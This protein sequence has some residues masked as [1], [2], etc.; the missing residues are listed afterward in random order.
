[1]LLLVR[2]DKIM[3]I[4]TKDAALAGTGIVLGIGILAGDLHKLVIGA[5]W[6][7][8]VMFWDYLGFGV[9]A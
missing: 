2:K 3:T 7:Y 9:G 6:P 1:M 8:L 4:S 5:V